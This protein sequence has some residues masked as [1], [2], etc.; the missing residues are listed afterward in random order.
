MAAD[1]LKTQGGSADGT[2]SDADRAVAAAVAV[3]WRRHR[4]EILRQV[5]ALEDAVGDG[6]A[7]RPD[8]G[9]RERGGRAAHKLAGSCG[10][11]GFPVAGEIAGRVEDALCGSVRPSTDQYVALAGMVQALR[12]ALE[13]GSPAL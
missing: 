5:G 9:S 4:A 2:A 6:L 13:T 12:R 11:F 10:T 1:V 3:V 7:G 8:K